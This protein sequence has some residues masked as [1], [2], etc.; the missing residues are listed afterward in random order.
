[1]KRKVWT[2]AGIGALALGIWA[3]RSFIAATEVFVRDA[4]DVPIYTLGARSSYSLALQNGTKV[5]K[6]GPIFGGVYPGGLA[7]ASAQ[8]A[9]AHLEDNGWDPVR[10]SV[11]QL[12]GDYC[13][14]SRDGHILRFLLVV[15]EAQ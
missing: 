3:V 9:R 11:Y 7:F 5:L 4:P 8:E 13:L 15:S 14:D 2:I 1:M 6:F 10:W 12:S